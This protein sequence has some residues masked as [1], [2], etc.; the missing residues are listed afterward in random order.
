LSNG[1]RGISFNCTRPVKTHFSS[2]WY[3][4]SQTWRSFS[5]EGGD[6]EIYGL[7]GPAKPARLDEGVFTTVAY[8]YG[9]NNAQ[10]DPVNMFPR[11]GIST[12]PY[13]PVSKLYNFHFRQGGVYFFFTHISQIYTYQ[14]TVLSKIYRSLL[15]GKVTY[16]LPPAFPTCKVEVSIF[17]KIS[18]ETSN[19][20]G[21]TL[22]ALSSSLCLPRCQVMLILQRLPHVCSFSRDGV[23]YLTDVT[24]VDYE[25]FT[26]GQLRQLWEVWD[27]WV[28]NREILVD[29]A[30]DVEYLRNFFFSNG[31]PCTHVIPW[32]MRFKMKGCKVRQR[33]R[34][35]EA[36]VVF[37]ELPESYF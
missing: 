35:S 16:S 32:K 14:L 22:E 2:L 26:D 18:E 31:R 28:M 19:E 1:P 30:I 10:G 7:D 8:I 5:H 17:S 21:I 4:S 37:D 34:Y 23:I 25:I 13:D 12:V 15:R 27:L 3:D 33:I 24:K 29:N 9:E 11:G 20:S 36:D 6:C